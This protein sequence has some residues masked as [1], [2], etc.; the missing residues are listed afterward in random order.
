MQTTKRS[1]CNFQG[2]QEKRK[3]KRHI[4]DK[5]NHH[6]RYVPHYKEEDMTTLLT[7]QRKDIFGCEEVLHVLSKKRGR[8]PHFKECTTHAPTFLFFNFYIWS[9]IKLP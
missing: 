5:P 7:T 1:S 2:K 6:H 8:L 9:N 3:K 4:S